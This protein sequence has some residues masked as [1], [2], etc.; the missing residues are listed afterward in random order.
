MAEIV[1]ANPFPDEP[2]ARVAV[3]FSSVPIAQAT[4]D[5][6]TGP[7]GERVVASSRELF[8]SYPNGMGRSKL[9][10]P[11]IAGV[12][13]VRNMNTAATLAKRSAR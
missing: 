6:L 8:I 11:R 13:T 9:K 12:T 3:V 1:R 10:L 4:F 5:G 2:P 7:D